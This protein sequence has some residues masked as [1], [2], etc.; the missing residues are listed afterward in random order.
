MSMSKLQSAHTGNITQPRLLCCGSCQI[1]WMRWTTSRWPSLLECSLRLCRSWHLTVK[2]AVLFRLGRYLPDLDLVILDWQISSRLVWKKLL[3]RNYA[4]VWRSTRICF[5]TPSV[6]AVSSTDL[7]QNCIIRT[8]RPQLCWWFPVVH[9]RAGVRITDGCSPVGCMCRR[10]WSMD[11][12]QQTEIECREDSA[13]LDRN[14][15]TSS[16]A[17]RHSTP[18]DTLSC[19]VWHYGHEPRRG[20]WLSAVHV[21]VSTSFVSWSQSRAP[22]L[23]RLS[24]LL[25]R[26]LFIVGLTSATLCW[27]EWPKFIVRNFSL[28]RTWLLVWCLE[29]AE[30]NTSHQFLKIY[31]GYL[32]VSE[33]SSRRPW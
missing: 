30:V 27:L 21:Y 14:W 19:W 8:V 2:A 28:W 1:Y 33:Q 12:V 23:D 11:G 29:F 10:S 20:S 25:C 18:V 24:I 9:Q 17:N 13:N 26:L 31:I 4:L 16:P 6:F 7:W 32:L 3:D 15:A 5:R 22:W